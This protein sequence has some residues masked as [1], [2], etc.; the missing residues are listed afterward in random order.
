[1]KK[2]AIPDTNIFLHYDITSID[3]CKELDAD[4]VEIIVSPTVIKELD[5]KKYDANESIAERATKN[6]SKIESFNSSKEEIRKNVRISA[7]IKEPKIDWDVLSLDSSLNDDRILGF[8][9][10]R[11]NSDDILVTNDSTPR[12]KGKELGISV[13]KLSA[14]MLPN[15]KSEERKQ[16]EKLKKTIQ[17]FQNKIPE[18]SIKLISDETT[19]EGL[20]K[21]SIKLHELSED[22]IEN[23]VSKRK[24]ELEGKISPITSSSPFM[25]DQQ[26][27]ELDVT[28]HL[29]S[30]KNYLKKRKT[31]D[32]ELLTILKLSFKMSC[33]KAPAEDIRCEIQFPNG[34][35][36]LKNEDVPELPTEPTKPVPMTNL[37]RQ[38]SSFSGLNFHLPSFDYPL[39]SSKEKNVLSWIDS[40]KIQFHIN[41]IRHDFE[42][43]LGTFYVKM[44]SISEAKPF[45]VSY[46]IHAIN[47]PE[48]IS[49]KIPIILEKQND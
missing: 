17:D 34:F 10:S 23:L 26:R 43:D 18:L 1:M 48:P 31:V 47:R 44:P 33:S 15:P 28:N 19:Q 7:E 9:K 46:Y 45:E 11:G 35:K 36:I 29:G 42:V 20:P 8:I 12:L 25:I 4:E 16:T 37:Q 2:Y 21:F 38:F 32:K 40:N 3:W 13:V 24:K 5:G 30:Y 41:K 49:N 6:L 27:Y 39:F 22:E 14:K